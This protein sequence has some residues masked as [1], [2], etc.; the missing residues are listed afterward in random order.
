MENDRD[1]VVRYKIAGEKVRGGGGKGCK[2]TTV[3][4]GLVR[5][6]LAP[7][8]TLSA[9]SKWTKENHLLYDEIANV[10]VK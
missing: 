3:E 10:M 5:G 8:I 2:R 4:S 7:C 1:G 9:G 6:N